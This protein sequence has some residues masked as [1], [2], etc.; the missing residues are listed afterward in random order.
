LIEFIEKAMDCYNTSPT[1]E[2]SAFDAS[3]NAPEQPV[4][5]Q[6]H[7]SVEIIKTEESVQPLQNILD[8][9]NLDAAAACLAFANMLERTGSTEQAEF[10]YSRMRAIIT[11]YSLELIHPE[12]PQKD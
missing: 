8:Q 3:G 6:T 10:F 7:D 2:C 9:K 12:S 1:P 5:V 11:Q 4:A